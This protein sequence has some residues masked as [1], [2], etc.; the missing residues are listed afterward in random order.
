MTPS[1]IRLSVVIPTTG[2]EHLGEIV[3][4]FLAEP[5]PAEVIVA[6]DRPDLD[7][8]YLEARFASDPRFVLVRNSRNLGLPRTL[9]RAIAAARGEIIVRND[10]DDPPVS[11]RLAKT[12]AYFEAH[13]DADIVFG[14]AIG[15][16]MASGRE[17]RIEGP[18]EEDAI[19]ARLLEQNFIVHS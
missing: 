7:C 9:N 19:K 17:W 13:P 16:E 1:P 14:F 3:A 8:S 4:S 10:D 2:N 12:L 11:D 15:R 18:T 5:I 6:V